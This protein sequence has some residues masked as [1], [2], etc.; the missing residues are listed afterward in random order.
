MST[1]KSVTNLAKTSGDGMQQMKF[2][3]KFETCPHFTGFIRA[4][5]KEMFSEGL[6]FDGSAALF[7]F[8]LYHRI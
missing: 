1:S 3:D 5:T 4:L 6:G 2:V 8:V 7:D